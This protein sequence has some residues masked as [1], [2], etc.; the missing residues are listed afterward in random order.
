MRFILHELARAVNNNDGRPIANIS[1][2]T[3]RTVRCVLQQRNH[4]STDTIRSLGEMREGG[5]GG[6]AWWSVLLK[7]EKFPLTKLQIEDFELRAQ[8]ARA[9]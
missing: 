4:F 2:E 6:Q 8:V 1:I 3:K 5:G 7:P 9:G